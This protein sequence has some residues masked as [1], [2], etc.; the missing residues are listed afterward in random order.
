[1]LYSAGTISTS[2]LH[3][4]EL[5]VLR[6]IVHRKTRSR[7]ANNTQLRVA[8][9]RQSVYEMKKELCRLNVRLTGSGVEN[10]ETVNT[11]KFSEV[12]FVETI[13]ERAGI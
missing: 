13:W 7:Y 4:F 3:K 6:R 11:A 5:H 12:Y 2:L 10:Y 8:L 9:K 1:V